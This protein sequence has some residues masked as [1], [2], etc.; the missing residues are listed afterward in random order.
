MSDQLKTEEERMR[1]CGLISCLLISIWISLMN[2]GFI[3][4]NETEWINWNQMKTNQLKQL[5]PQ[6]IIITVIKGIKQWKYF[7]NDEVVNWFDEL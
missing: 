4:A 5:M 6:W 2:S 7:N 3:S 1:N